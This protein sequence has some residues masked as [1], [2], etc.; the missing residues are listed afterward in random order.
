MSA[1]EKMEVHS[2]EDA[3]TPVPASSKTKPPP[4][5]WGRKRSDVGESANIDT[6]VKVLRPQGNL[7]ALS[8]LSLL[9]EAASLSLRE[10]VEKVHPPK[11]SEDGASQDSDEN[12]P[13]FLSEHAYYAQ[14]NVEE[15]QESTATLSAE[16]DNEA[17]DE[18]RGH[19][20][21]W[22]DHNY[23]QVP[24][25]QLL[26]DW[27]REYEKTQALIKAIER[28]TVEQ[29]KEI[30]KVEE[31]PKKGRKRKITNEALAD[32]TNKRE[33]KVSRELASLLEPVKPKE[34]IK[35]EPRTY[36]EE[37]QVFY[38]IF[39]EGVDMEDITFLKKCYEHLL[40]TDDPMFYWLNDIL[41]VDH[42]LTNIPDPVPPRKKRKTDHQEVPTS[43]HKTGNIAFHFHF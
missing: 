22:V 33:N 18:L 17:E 21:I 13:R 39:N 1:E 25:P 34:I 10:L 42:P 7:D 12:R 19:R 9:S 4:K 14:P 2:S 24:P 16:E 3:I 27:T 38:N 8:G 30:T 41:W 36:E 26:A 6:N 32:I 35:Y 23:C 5:K 28:K 15:D 20:L 29:Q 40:S 43:K 11:P 37:R 31:K